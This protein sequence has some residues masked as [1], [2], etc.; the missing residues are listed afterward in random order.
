[1]NTI[2]QHFTEKVTSEIEK[3]L[4]KILLGKDSNLSQLI[5]LVD[6]NLKELGRN[7]IK[8]VLEESDQIIRESSAR[9]KSWVIQSRDMEKTLLT[10]FGEV[11]Y[12]RTYYQSKSKDD[13]TYLLDDHFGIARY[14]RMDLGLEAK[15][16]E[17]AKDYSYQ[18]SADL[19]V[20]ETK[21]SRQTVKNKLDKLGAID[22]RE[23]D[24]LQT[25]KKQIKELYIEAD[26]DHIS[27]QTGKNTIT[28]LVYVHEGRKKSGNRNKLKNS[29]YF[30][31]IYKDSEDLWLEV[32][33]YIDDNYDW[34][35]I[36]KIYL[37]GDGAKWIKEGLN[38]IPKTKYV[39]DRYHLNKYVLQA[40][41]HQPKKRYKLWHALNNSNQEEVREIFK[42]I[43][44]N[45]K[46]ESKQNA[47][48]EARKY[49]LNNWFGIE[50]YNQDQ[51]VLGC[52]AEGHVSH[53]LSARMSSRPLGW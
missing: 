31:G 32:V 25:T 4:E 22:N 20:S 33:N 40:T 12:K 1:M 3:E 34:D 9:K 23:C 52:S 26:E 45:T 35:T 6:G 38:W 42:E 18:Q 21:L 44:N 47:V 46:K 30:A 19:A 49:I 37:A 41:G 8:Y 48:K 43:I 51:N 39:L 17:L 36:E 5:N 24:K 14:Q 13:F 7:I 29:K 16:I 10:E 50:I 53:V 2:I 28:K 27:L 15:L 11:K